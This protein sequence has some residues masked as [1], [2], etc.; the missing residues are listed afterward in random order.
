MLPGLFLPHTATITRAAGLCLCVALL[1]CVP[2]PVVEPLQPADSAT[3][4][5]AS[6]WLH[7]EP[8]AFDE[9]EQAVVVLDFFGTWYPSSREVIQVLKDLSARYSDRGLVILSCSREDPIVVEPLVR[10]LSIPYRVFID[11]GGATARRFGVRTLPT[12]LVYGAGL[13][14]VYSGHPLRPGFA[15]QVRQAIVAKEQGD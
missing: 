10:E 15:E 7:G 14:P 11:A 4:L 13:E 8:V 12:V 9:L 5:F 3:H 6:A 1:G 2:T